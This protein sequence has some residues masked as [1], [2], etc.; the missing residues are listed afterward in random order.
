M[1]KTIFAILLIT[2]QAFLALAFAKNIGVSDTFE[3][4]DKLKREKYAVE[5]ESKNQEAACYQKFA[6]SNCLQEIKK[7]TQISLKSIK[8]REL[9]IK[10]SQRD[11]K[12]QFDEK[13]QSDSKNDLTIKAGE[14]ANL[15]CPAKSGHTN[16]IETVGE[17]PVDKT[18]SGKSRAKQAKRRLDDSNRKLAD[19]LKK[20]R[21]RENK[22]SLSPQN[23]AKYNQ[24]IALAAAKKDALE[25]ESLERKKP[26][27]ASLPM[28]NIISGPTLPVRTQ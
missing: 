27:S 21:I 24:K 26:K 4:L 16:F 23:V 22:T 9:E 19:S 14:A 17:L 12:I 18:V 1:K 28:P 25:K 10:D 20:N 6:V 5:S 13:K 2:L 15:K 11:A 8:R 7:T 3:E